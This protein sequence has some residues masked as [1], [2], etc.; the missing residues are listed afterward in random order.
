MRRKEKKWHYS[1]KYSP[2][3]PV[4]AVTLASQRAMSK[5]QALI[6]TGADITVISKAKADEAGISNQPPISL[7]LMKSHEYTGLAPVFEVKL[8]LGDKIVEITPAIATISDEVIIGR[9]VL[10]KF[11]IKLDGPRE[12]ASI[13]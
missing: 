11:I 3:A 5:G 4:A 1:H 12:E 10:N 8:K 9:D 7:V 2:P 6:D 13:S